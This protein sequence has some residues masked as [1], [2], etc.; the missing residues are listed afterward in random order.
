[1]PFTQLQ[2]IFDPLY[3]KG[4]QWYWKGAFV[5]D[6]GDDAI[7]ENIKNA[8]NFPTPYCGMH[9]YPVNGAC[10]TKS[11]GDTAWGYRHANWS[12]VIVGVDPDPVNKG[13]ITK[14]A[15]DYWSGIFPYSLGGGY[16][17][18]MMSED[19][20][21]GRASFGNNYDRLVAVKRKYDPDNLFRIN[22]NIQP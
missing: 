19:N 20:D 10:H 21:R 7:R 15:K 12:Q 22:Q 9:L 13:K 16:V 8:R 5:R 14:C 17:N 2:A 1:M 18:F 11:D 6:L 3:P 4:M